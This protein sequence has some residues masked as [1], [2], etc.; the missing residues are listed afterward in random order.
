MSVGK[1]IAIRSRP[2]FACVGVMLAAVVLAGDAFASD[3]SEV[4]QV[5]G[6]TVEARATDS[7]FNEHRGAV[8]VCAELPA[9][10]AFV[11]DTARFREWLPYTRDAQLL[12]SAGD[13]LV[14][15]V[16]S[17]TPGPVKDRD[18]VYRVSRHPAN[19]RGV[20]LDLV[21]LPDYQY[22][23]TDATRIREAEGRWQLV[24]TDQG[25]DVSYQLFVHPGAV[26]TFAANGRMASAVGKTLANLASQFPCTQI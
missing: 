21:G 9:L 13:H 25:L 1:P 23:H 11:S 15:Y 18:M 24:E 17:T 16:R 20:T 4:R 26:P 8:R 14:D 12:E 19:E 6:V 22:S 10:E 3:W 5:E 2:A 7:G